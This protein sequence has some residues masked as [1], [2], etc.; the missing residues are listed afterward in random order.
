MKFSVNDPDYI[1]SPY[2][3]MTRKHWLEAAKMVLIGVFSHI[4]SLDDPVMPPRSENKISYPR[5]DSKPGVVGAAR[6][7]GLARTMCMAVPLML[8]DETLELGGI[9]LR[10]Y[11]AHQIVT[12]MQAGTPNTFGT[13]Q[14]LLKERPDGG[15]YQQTVECGIMAINLMN[16]RSVIWDR[17]TQEEKDIV[18]KFM[19][20]FGHYRT[21]ESNWR[22][23]NLHALTFLKCVGYP[24]DETIYQDHLEYL[25]S[26]YAG[27]GWYRDGNLFDYYSAWEFMVDAN[28]WCD[29]YGYEHEPEMAE[30]IERNHDAFIRSYWR[31]FGRNGESILWGRSGTYRFCTCSPFAA[32]FWL[33]HTN[34]HPG[35]ARRVMSGNLLQFLTREEMFMN[36]VPCLGFYGPFSAM[37]QNYSCSGSPFWM[38]KAFLCLCLP[39][40]H[41][42]WTDKEEDGW[43]GLED[44]ECSAAGA[45]G[46]SSVTVDGSGM[47][48]VNHRESG[49]TEIK[50]SKFILSPE[51]D[52]LPAYSRVAFSSAL[53][54]EKFSGGPAEAMAYFCKCS[55]YPDGAVP[56]SMAYCGR[57]GGVL[58]R[59]AY[60]DLPATRMDRVDLAD[61]EVPYGTVRV[62]RFRMSDRPFTVTLGNYGLPVEGDQVQVEEGEVQ[63]HPYR[64]AVSGGMQ[65][66]V[67]LLQGWQQ[68]NSVIREGVS[69]VSDKSC[70]LYAEASRKEWYDAMPPLAC[71]MLQKPADVPFTEEELLPVVSLEMKKS[72]K[73]DNPFVCELKMRD[74]R[75]LTVNYSE[76]DGRTVI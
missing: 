57:D 74:G 41:P 43:D 35:L 37:V 69:A 45:Q 15:P 3:G 54:W 4:H 50:T 49:I 42:F 63:G 17:Y 1:T 59:R 64:I 23:F 68:V 66:A 70:L 76:L 60:F 72:S 16:S 51:S 30:M 33:K 58:Y 61:I 53:P 13:L 73:W 40:D 75:C 46:V 55:R 44:N 2:T 65:T 71:V 26:L 20:D 19:S 34:L 56:T 7:E 10:D 18:A 32:S 11:Y 31:M 12:G 27:D 29:W 8:E 21:H 28:C 5:P 67:V 6:Y 14:E 48:F 47:Q 24:V 52:Y 36:G 9:N 38:S 62:D 39:E 25:F 22:F